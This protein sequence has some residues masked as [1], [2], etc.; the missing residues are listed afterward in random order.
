MCFLSIHRPTQLSAHARTAGDPDNYLTYYKRATVYLALGK[1]KAALDDL[2][3]IIQKKVDFLEARMQRGQLFLKLGRIDEAHIDFEWVLRID[4]ERME[5]HQQYSVIEAIRNELQNVDILIDHQRWIDAIEVLSRL[6]HDMPYDESLRDL[7]ATCYEKVGDK[8]NAIVDVR[9]MTKM[10]RDDTPGLLRL[11]Q[12]HYE[13]GEIEEA[14][15]TTRECLRLDQDHKQCKTLYRKVKPLFGHV[16]AMHAH[17]ATEK[18]DECIEKAMTAFKLEPNVL[19]IVQHIK[20]RQCHCESKGANA[21]DAIR[22]CTEA[23]NI[24]KDDVYVLCDRAEA[25]LNNDDFESAKNDFQQALHLSAHLQRAEEGLRKVQKLIKQSKTRD[26]Y[27]ILGVKRN[28]NKP[29]IMRAYRKLASKW[30]PDNYRGEEKKKA[31]KI[32][33]DIAAAKE[34]LTNAEKRSQFDNGQDPLDPEAQSQ[35]NPF[36]HHGGHGFPFHDMPFQFK[37]HFN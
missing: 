8:H 21:A 34:V 25:Y 4:P 13:I 17:A 2:N 27:K 14:L 11:S 33:I 36:R 3:E 7:R 28:A 22:T 5:A 1:P 6:I 26:Y 32:F 18:W 9:A 12:L 35:S 31:E 24:A 37:F 30:H 20:A 23:L 29:D 10:R 15:N 19:S 16:K